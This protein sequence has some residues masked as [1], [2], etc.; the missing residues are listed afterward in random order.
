MVSNFVDAIVKNRQLHCGG[1]F[2]KLSHKC[3]LKAGWRERTGKC[4]SQILKNESFFWKACKKAEHWNC[5]FFKKKCNPKSSLVHRLCSTDQTRQSFN[6]YS[7]CSSFVWNV[8]FL[9]FC[10]IFFKGECLPR[11]EMLAKHWNEKGGCVALYSQMTREIC[12]QRHFNMLMWMLI[13]KM[14]V[15]VYADRQ[16]K[17]AS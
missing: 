8:K 1:N 4:K 7:L 13:L 12:R 9:I 14:Q 10:R 16:Y 17:L 15:C 2:L 3:F 5:I 11:P 6:F